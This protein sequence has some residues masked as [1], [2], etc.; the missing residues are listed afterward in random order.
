MTLPLQGRG[1]EFKSQRAH[2]PPEFPIGNVVR[3]VSNQRFAPFSLMFPLE[4]VAAL[5][6]AP[7]LSGPTNPFLLEKENGSPKEKNILF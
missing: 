3:D 6:P 2:S 1:P 7:F 4:D 5:R